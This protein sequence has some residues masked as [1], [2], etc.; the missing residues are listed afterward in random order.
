LLG[1]LAGHR[2]YLKELRTQLE[3]NAQAQ[4]RGADDTADGQAGTKRPRGRPKGSKNSKKAKAPAAS[5]A[6]T[7]AAALATDGGSGSAD[8]GAAA[9]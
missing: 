2:R 7:G 6:T 3:E 5:V 9:S 1:S 8:G 4:K